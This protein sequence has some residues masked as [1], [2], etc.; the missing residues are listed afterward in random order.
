MITYNTD[1]I[2]E[3]FTNLQIFVLYF[4]FESELLKYIIFM[5]YV[6]T[7]MYTYFGPYYRIQFL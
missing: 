4:N 7:Y 6:H 2:S 5:M 1:L 3:M